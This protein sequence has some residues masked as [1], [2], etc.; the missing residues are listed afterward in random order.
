[1]GEAKFVGQVSGKD[2]PPHFKQQ[3][4]V[5][6]RSGNPPKYARLCLVDEFTSVNMMLVEDAVKKHPLTV[7]NSCRRLDKQGRPGNHASN[8]EIQFDTVANF[9]L[10]FGY[11]RNKDGTDA[12]GNHIS[13]AF[14]EF[15]Q[16]VETEDQRRLGIDVLLN[17]CGYGN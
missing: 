9:C 14:V 12:N 6:Y 10:K 7:S 17:V 5:F 13:H 15:G 3:H 8:F 4:T 16:R 1:M 11:S 2:V